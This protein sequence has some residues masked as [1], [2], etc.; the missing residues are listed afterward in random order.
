MFFF[1]VSFFFS[2]H[3]AGESE[4]LFGK[5]FKKGGWPRSEFVVS[6]KI[7]WGGS[8]VNQRGL[9]RKH[10]LEGT[11]KALE[12]L[13][14]D[15]V[16]LIFAH[17]PDPQTPI[18][19][20]VRAFNH[21][22]HHGK[23]L[24]WGTSE[25]SAQ[26]IQEA[27]MVAKQLGLIPPV[28]EQP[29][30]NM[31]HRERF[32]TEYYPLYQSPYKMGT[33]VWSPLAGGIL[34]GKYLEEVKEGRYA[35]TEQRPDYEK[36]MIQNFAKKYFLTGEQATRRVEILRKLVAYA[37]N[38][39]GCSMAQLALSWILHNKNVSTAIIGATSVKQLEE[40]ITSLQVLPKLSDEIMSEI[41]R[42]LENTP[43]PWVTDFG[44]DTN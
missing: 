20:I 34:T 42:I 6:T 4:I 36:V 11:Q 2:I 13:Q 9:S 16:D 43:T 28:M 39:L 37:K 30:Y 29:Q 5:V 3:I 24:Y 21:L 12:R 44:R 26:Q 14:L 35:I 1:L 18:E 33:T 32:E 25:W 10:I 27:Y 22:I 15:Y 17:R 23:A 38:K 7:F 31:F 8:G 19:E 41:E 40:N